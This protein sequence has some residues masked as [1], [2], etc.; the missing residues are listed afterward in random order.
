MKVSIRDRSNSEAEIRSFPSPTDMVPAQWLEGIG[1]LI[2]DWQYDMVSMGY[3]GPVKKNRPLREPVNLGKGWVDFDYE[4]A[5]GCPVKVI[6][7][8]AMQALGSYRGGDMLF[9]GLGTGLGTAMIM[10][11][12]VVAMEL[13]HLPFRGAM[14]FEQALGQ[15]GL[16]RH[17]REVW[18]EDL[19]TTIGLLS[20]VFSPDYVMLGGGNASHLR[21]Q[22]LPDDIHIGKNESAFTGGALL[23]GEQS[24]G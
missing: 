7:D 23:W 6:N 1:R 5:L 12:R 24:P 9:L 11:N 13:A 20:H 19:L 4:A 10:K 15:R 21:Q 22:S 2:G 8:A 3:P 14:S 18:F 17:G 16:D